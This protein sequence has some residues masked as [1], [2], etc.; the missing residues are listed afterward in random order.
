M[1]M[2]IK[3]ESNQCQIYTNLY[4]DMPIL[5]YGVIHSIGDNF[6]PSNWKIGDLV[7]RGPGDYIINLRTCSWA[8]VQ[9]L[10]KRSFVIRCMNIGEKFEIK[11]VG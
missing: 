10:E 11:R 4:V 8:T 9:S 1:E 7:F 2:E 5:S 3:T 6:M